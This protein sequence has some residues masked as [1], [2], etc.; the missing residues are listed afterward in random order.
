MRAGG[1]RKIFKTVAIAV[2]Y[3]AAA[4]VQRPFAKGLR[5]HVDAFLVRV[6]HMRRPILFSGV[7]LLILLLYCTY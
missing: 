5:L 3:A 1:E 6:S 2:L 4:V 7:K